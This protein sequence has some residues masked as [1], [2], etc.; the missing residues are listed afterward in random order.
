MVIALIYG[1]SKAK[2]PWEPGI[3]FITAIVA[4]F[5]AMTS[6][7]FGPFILVPGMAAITAASLVITPQLK[8]P[9][10]TML[11]SCGAVVVPFALEAMG[12]LTRSYTFENGVMT[13]HPNLHELPEVPV[14]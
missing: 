1:A 9:I 2:D 12:V 8:H 5:L 14:S 3:Y 13:I 7:M 4:A 11:L 10:L 6:R